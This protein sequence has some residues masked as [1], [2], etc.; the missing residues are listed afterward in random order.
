MK[1]IFK[2]M[3]NV[4]RNR[5]IQIIIS[6]SFIFV[7]ILTFSLLVILNVFPNFSKMKG[8]MSNTTFI[9]GNEFCLG[10]ECFNVIQDNNDGTVTALA[11]Y[12]LYVGRIYTDENTYTEISQDDENYGKQN[13]NAKGRVYERDSNNNVTNADPYPRVGVLPF[14][15]NKYWSTSERY[16]YNE[17]S[18]IYN[19]VQ[20]YQ[21][22]LIDQGYSSVTATILSEDQIRYLGCRGLD[23]ECDPSVFI[24][25]TYWLG[26]RGNDSDVQFLQENNRYNVTNYNTQNIA[27]IR[28]VITINKSDIP[29]KTT[30]DI[31]HKEFC[32]LSECFYTLSDNGDT[33][34]A[35]AKYNLLVGKR[36][37]NNTETNI[38]VIEEGYGLQNEQAKGYDG[39]SQDNVVGYLTFSQSNYWIENNNLKPKYGNSYPAFVF[40][41]NSNLYSYVKDYQD[42]FTETLGLSSVTA[43]LMSG[44]QASDLKCDVNSYSCNNAQSFVTNTTYWLGSV[45]NENVLVTTS[46]G[47]HYPV[48]GG[49][50]PAG[51]RPVI[52]ISKS[53]MNKR[54]YSLTSDKYVIDNDKKEIDVKGYT[55]DS[56]D[57]SD[58]VVNPSGFTRY[59]QNDEVI[60]A[61]DGK[62]LDSYKIVNY[63]LYYLYSNYFDI[64]NVNK[65]IDAKGSLLSSVNSY[66]VHIQSYP[67]HYYISNLQDDKLY[68]KNSDDSS[69]SESY[70]IINYKLYNF[71]S[72]VYAINE[73][74]RT[75]DLNGEY[76]A[77]LSTYNFSLSPSNYTK[78]F[79]DET[80]SIKDP[81][82]DVVVTYTFINYKIYDLTSSVYTINNENKTINANGKLL[83]NIYTSDFSV[84][85][86]PYYVNRIE[87]DKLIINSYND[88]NYIDEYTF[89]N[90][91]TY[92]LTSY[93]YIV[94]ESDK[95]IDVKGDVIGFI[96]TSSFSIYPNKYS[97]YI[98]NDKLQVKQGNEIIDEYTFIN[99]SSYKLTS[100]NYEVNSENKTIDVKNDIYENVIN[101]SYN[102]NLT[103]Y[104]Y[105]KAIDNDKLYVKNE[106]GSIIDT[107]TFVNVREKLENAYLNAGFN[108]KNFYTCV[109]HTGFYRYYNSNYIKNVEPDYLLTDEEYE[110]INYMD[111]N[112]MGIKDVTGIE[113]LTN[114]QELDI[115]KNEISNMNLN[116]N[117]KLYYLNA[118]KNKL[119]NMDL[120]NNIELNSIYLANNKIEQIEGLE[121]LNKLE[122]LI[123]HNNNLQNISLPN[124]NDLHILNIYDNDKL[125]KLRIKKGESIDYNKILNF[126]DFDVTIANNK[127]ISYD[128]GIISGLSK[129]KTYFTYTNNNIMSI[130]KDYYELGMYD[131][132]G[133]DEDDFEQNAYIPYFIKT[134]VEVYDDEKNVTTSK[135]TAKK[136]NNDE[137]TTKKT[138][139]TIKKSRIIG[140]NKKQ[141]RKDQ[142]YLSDI[143]LVGSKIS[144]FS[145]FAIKEKNRNLIIEKDGVK[146]TI[147]GLN[148][149]KISGDIDLS[150]NVLPI[151]KSKLKDKI[152]GD[153]LVIEFKD[154]NIEINNIAVEFS[155]DDELLKHIDKN[156]TSIY[157]F[158]NDSLIKL[159]QNAIINDHKVKINI[160][161][162]DYHVLSSKK[163]ILKNNDSIKS[164]KDYKY[165]LFIALGVIILLIIGYS[166]TIFRNKQKA[167]NI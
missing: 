63:G 54:L 68:I 84:T 114:L 74:D 21:R 43:T 103:P 52:T 97:L 42:F 95:T 137:E 156:K 148:V 117:K 15:D 163:L 164:K 96:Y 19:Y 144:L 22:Y 58:I 154:R 37:N 130:K 9:M 149:Q 161:D 90:Y 14:S 78:Y 146:F 80:L 40:D 104:N 51:V 150:F 50:Y 61:K 18:N 107:Y 143:N 153:G 60:I 53:D 55:L 75:I 155:L 64:D 105:T 2:K 162:F 109:F 113:K 110:S 44:E 120:S 131:S 133:I 112:S 91:K 102:F 142:N 11:K 3:K 111:C 36:F 89:I 138:N 141:K 87:D 73:Q 151:S 157:K 166:V 86:Y 139:S 57:I 30:D 20:N 92:S 83:S 76:R 167:Q 47:I 31:E 121:K 147:N 129:G 65:I 136:S 69:F 46:D 116:N 10:E 98:E 41:E 108:D 70:T 71:T 128:D 72:S 165:I 56:I 1:D 59:R 29:K 115:Y 158:S 126:S 160:D 5:K 25:T 132:S 106:S 17:N 13:I 34:T 48:Y 134:T 26:F 101:N 118:D 27:G 12:N 77:N 82:G 100:N 125:N 23:G 85:P 7:L 123:L 4:L 93:N 81:N 62:K 119:T 8:D 66:N 88:R 38:K 6:I 99:V 28:P 140:K 145:L 127:I 49:N 79:T 135:I 32:I 24:T 16:I 39:V 94:N 35:L 122:V 159:N 45:Y 124:I 33:V 152:I 67:Y